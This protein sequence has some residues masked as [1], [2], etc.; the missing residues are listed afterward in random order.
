MLFTTFKN[1]VKNIFN[2]YI[3]Y[4]VKWKGEEIRTKGI[5]MYTHTFMCIHRYTDK[6]KVFTKDHGLIL[7]SKKQY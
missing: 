6:W 5:H 4:H 1:V 2:V 7:D 3:K